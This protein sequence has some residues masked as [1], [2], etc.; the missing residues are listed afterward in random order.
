MV[1]AQ[2]RSF[3]LKHVFQ[4]S[5]GPVPWA[6]ATTDGQLAKTQKA[7]LMEALEKTTACVDSTPSDAGWVID[8]MV[9][10]QSVRSPPQRLETLRRIFSDRC[11]SIFSSKSSC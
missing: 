4:Y 5:L 7:K 11:Q 6:L 10:L 1:I 2:S 9:V 8:A 3:D